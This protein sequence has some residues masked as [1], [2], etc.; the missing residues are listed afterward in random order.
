MKVYYKSLKKIRGQA[1]IYT[2][3]FFVCIMT[4]FAVN[5]L[6]APSFQLF[7]GI[8]LFPIFKSKILRLK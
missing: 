4:Q 6:R 5:F 7:L 8:A 3:L 1:T 2:T